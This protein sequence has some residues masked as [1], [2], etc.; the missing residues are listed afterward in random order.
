MRISFSFR[1][2]GGLN[3]WSAAQKLGTKTPIVT[4]SGINACAKARRVSRR[5][6][7]LTIGR[8]TNLCGRD[9][10]D[11]WQFYIQLTE[12]EAAFKNLKTICNCARFTINSNTASKRTSLS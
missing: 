9:P 7:V 3:R 10:E 5:L 6:G 12:I 11:L 1:N 8:R 4:T 2:G